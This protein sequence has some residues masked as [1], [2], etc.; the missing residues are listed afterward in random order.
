MIFDQALEPDS[1]ARTR[2]RSY[3]GSQAEAIPTMVESL[4]RDE[5]E[6]EGH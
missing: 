5:H 2:A 3:D 4:H 6:A 1:V